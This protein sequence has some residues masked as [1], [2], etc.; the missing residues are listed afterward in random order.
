MW[1]GRLSRY[2]DSLRAGWFG[3]RIPVGTRFSAPFQTVPRAYP[4]FYTMGTESFL[5]VK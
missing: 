5:G 4:A 1:A 2:G 3:D